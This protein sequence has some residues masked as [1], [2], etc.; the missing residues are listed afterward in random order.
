MRDEVREMGEKKSTQLWRMSDEFWEEIKDEVPETKRD[1]QKHY[2]HVPGQGRKPMPAR[3]LS[4]VN[5]SRSIDNF[6]IGSK[7]TF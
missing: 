4:G 6:R 7:S 1:A 3:L 5:S 2:V